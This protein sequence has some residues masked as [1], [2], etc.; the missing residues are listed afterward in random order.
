MAFVQID[1][2][3]DKTF[4]KKNNNKKSTFKNRIHAL[5]Y[6]FYIALARNKYIS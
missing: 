1:I 4:K 3:S 6:L 2:P 5:F